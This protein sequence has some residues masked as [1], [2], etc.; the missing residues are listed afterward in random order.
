MRISLSIFKL[1]EKFG[2]SDHQQF[3][4]ELTFYTACNAGQHEGHNNIAD[5]DDHCVAL[6]RQIWDDIINENDMHIA[7]RS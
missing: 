6:D 5:F 2:K 3:P 4:F 7:W 1:R